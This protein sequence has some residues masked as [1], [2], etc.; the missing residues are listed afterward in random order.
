[1]SWKSLI[2]CAI[3]FLALPAGSADARQRGVSPAAERPPATVTPQTYPAELIEAGEPRFVARCGFCHGRDAGGG[4]GG[5]D[6]TRSDLVA[7]DDYGSAIEPY[8]LES[9]GS[10]GVHDIEVEEDEL[11]GIVAFIHARKAVA[12]AMLGGRRF[13]EPEDLRTGDPDAGREYFNGAGGCS[14][15]HSPSGDLAGIASRREGLDL[16]RAMLAPRP[17]ERP[18]VRVVTSSGEVVTGRLIERDEFMIAITDEEGQRREW[19]TGDVGFAVDDPMEAHFEIL[20]RYTDE[21]MHDVYAYL[22]TL[23]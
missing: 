1:M 19:A 8:I 6:L 12:E 23:R 17:S 15:C 7:R 2:G 16:M 9:A 20:G 11:R 13:V 18:E 3:V 4:E 10:S 14:D 21:E 22:E 5:P